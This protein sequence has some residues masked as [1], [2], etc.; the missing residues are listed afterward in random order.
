MALDDGRVISNFIVQAL[1]E[2]DITVYGDG[3]QTRSFC[4]VDDMIEGLIRMMD[5]PDSFLGPI[6]VGNP[7]EF[8]II[9]LAETVIRMTK[10]SSKIVF[11]PL[12]QD[13]PVQRRPDISLAVEMLGWQPQINLEDGLLKTIDYFR[14]AIKG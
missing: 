11:K 3:K 9:D 10:S 6:N 2:K 14:R 12:P 1:K 8:S 13:D 7:V 5:T 4:Y